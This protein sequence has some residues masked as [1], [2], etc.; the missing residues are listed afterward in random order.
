MAVFASSS[1]FKPDLTQAQLFLDDYWIERCAFVERVWHQLMKH[2]DPVLVAE[3]PWERWGPVMYGS[4]VRQGELFRMWYAG[5][6]RSPKPAILYAES[7]DGVLWRKPKL[8]LHE[9]CGSMENNAVIVSLDPEKG[10]IDDITVIDDPTDDAWPLKALFWDSAE[11]GI[12]LARSRDGIHWDRQGCVLPDWGDRFNAIPHRVDGRFVLLAR[13]PKWFGCDLKRVVWRTESPDLITWSAPQLVLHPDPEDPAMMQFYSATGFGYGDILL[14]SIERMHMSP[15]KLDSELIWS[16]D[17]GQT[18]SRS[19]TRPAFIPWGEDRR[20]D[21][22]WIN[23]PASGPIEMGN[24]LWFYYSGRSAGHAQPAPRNHGA[25]GL[26][27]LRRDG[28]CSLRAVEQP[29][30]ITTRPMQWISGELGLNVDMRRDIRS[31]PTNVLPGQVRV[32]VRDEVGVAIAGYAL[33]DCILK[34][35]NS[36]GGYAAVLWKDGKQ[37]AALADQSIRLHFELKDT[38]LYA[39]KVMLA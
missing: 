13:T 2:P 28:F 20:W 1:E 10:L 9:R 25:I 33:D 4:V 15:D 39:F 22:T 21:D 36:H 23:L 27:L 32:E 17:A 29:A 7:D 6:S 16:R 3:H 31:H 5:W 38:H 37:L 34:P 26:S 14:G 24:W 18:W 12:H 11:Y 8:G 35:C 30:F 19:R